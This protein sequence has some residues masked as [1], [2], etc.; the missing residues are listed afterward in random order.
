MFYARCTHG[1][2]RSCLVH[3]AFISCIFWFV[4][5]RF[6]DVCRNAANGAVPLT[7]VG[8]VESLYSKLSLPN[9]AILK[10]SMFPVQGTITKKSVQIKLSSR[11]LQCLLMPVV[12]HY[13]LPPRG[14]IVR[15][16]GHTYWKLTCRQTLRLQWLNLIL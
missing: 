9:S 16:F 15:C 11:Q 1:Y 12:W 2:G 7:I 14:S 6:V 4:S 10:A 13:V 3:P 5:W 8:A